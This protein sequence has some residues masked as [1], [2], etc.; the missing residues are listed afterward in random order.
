MLL[1]PVLNCTKNN[2]NKGGLT[3]QR[4]NA[5]FVMVKDKFSEDLFVT[6]TEIN[7][8]NSVQEILRSTSVRRVHQR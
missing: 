2:V 8:Q 1:D 6:T 3:A 5:A 4:E 7:L